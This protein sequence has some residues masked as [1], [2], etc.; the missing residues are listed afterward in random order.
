M[1]AYPSF[2]S[3]IDFRLMYSSYSKRPA[4][5]IN[6]CS[7]RSELVLLAI[8]LHMLSM[9][10]KLRKEIKHIFPDEGTVSYMNISKGF[11]VDI[12]SSSKFLAPW[13]Q[14]S[15]GQGDA[16]ASPSLTS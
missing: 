8:E 2:G 5:P 10:C 15:G 6:S 7:T 16:M 12:S 3:L 14:P 11:Q 9:K 1:L 4:L 13:P